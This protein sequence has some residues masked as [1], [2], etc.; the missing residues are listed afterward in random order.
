MILARHL[1]SQGFQL[2][3]SDIGPDFFF[4][5]DGR[6]IWV[7]AISPKPTGIPEDYL[8]FQKEGEVKVF[9]VPHEQILLR[10]T[11]A[12]KDKNDKLVGFEKRGQHIEGY[13]EK[14]IVCR[15]ASYVIAVDAS[16]LGKS[17]C[18]L[19]GVTQQP[20][21]VEAVFP[22]GPYAIT[23]NTETTEVV[24][25]G[26]T[27]RTEIAKPPSTTVPT[28]SFFDARYSGVSA[29]IGTMAGVNAS[30]ELTAPVIV[31]H[32]P[33]ATNPIPTGILGAS[34]EYV[35]Q[36]NEDGIQISNVIAAGD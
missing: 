7:E 1:S 20:Y 34:A 26:Y 17:I 27:S 33:N 14:G 22:V 25:S 21:A 35:A 15:D 13:Q 4:E 23:I 36:I 31:V 18:E 30:C 9:D 2:K 28:D 12:L 32:N 29:I 3:S 24:G 6:Q 5:Y 19:Y 10:W 16:Q 11:S 8:V